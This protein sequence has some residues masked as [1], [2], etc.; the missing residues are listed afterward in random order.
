M[1]QKNSEKEQDERTSTISFLD[2][3]LL[4]NDDF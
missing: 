1:R 3:L 4:C 2:T